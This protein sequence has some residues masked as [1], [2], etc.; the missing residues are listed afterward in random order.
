MRDDF[1]K[2]NLAL[3]ALTA[4]FVVLA[5]G[6]VMAAA[7]DPAPRPTFVRTVPLPTPTTIRNTIADI[8]AAGGDTS[9]FDCYAC[10]DARKPVDVK[11]GA[12]GRITLPKE[13]LD[14]VFAMRNCVACHG[15]NSR[16]AVEYAADG[17]FKVPAA[18]RDLLSISHG[19]NNRNDHC[20][21]CHNPA[22]LDELVTRDGRKL[23]FD[24]ATL[25][26]ASCHGPTYRDW[27]AGVHG[28]TNGYWNAALGPATRVHCTS[29]H[30]PHSPAFPQLIP[31]P[32]PPQPGRRADVPPPSHP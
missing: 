24:E 10:H 9:G 4:V 11:V 17:T 19:R 29:C 27:E 5:I 6:F 8:K 22:K 16:L 25:L 3:A 26:C 15:A 2:T 28:R 12:D 1:R 23:A 31:R 20:F 21:N 32:G 30:D 13:H 7:R 18:H 14:L